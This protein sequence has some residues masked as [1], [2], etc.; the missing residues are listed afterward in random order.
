[1]R[2]LVPSF[3]FAAVSLCAVPAWADKIAVLPFSSPRNL[4]KPELEQARGWTREAVL[5]KGHTFATPD[6]M[7]SAEAAVKDGVP[8]TSQEYIAA[9]TAVGAPWT[10]A[11]RVE[12]N[13][14]PPST[15]P[16]GTVEEGYTT[17]RI[18]LEACLVASG[19]VES[20]AREVLADD[21]DAIAEMIALLVRPQGIADAEIPWERAGV[22]RPKPKPKPPA[23][24]PQ[25]R[26]PTPQEPPPQAPPPSKPAAPRAVY[27][28]GHALAI[29]ASIGVSNAIVRP[30]GARGPSWALPVGAVVGVALPDVLAGLE[31]KANLTSQVVGPR[32]LE[33][34][35]GARYA[36]APIG[37]GV[38]F[39]VGPELLLGAHVA[40]G[41][42]KTTRFLTHG[43]LFVAYG[44]TENL[45]AEVAGDLAV[46]AGGSGTLL[47]GGATARAVVR[48]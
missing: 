14:I 17:Y 39:F 31:L 35:A 40:L 21:T 30:S 41:A 29:G 15:L 44:I 13:D 36:F 37:D 6:E 38:R 43:A 24:P 23:P 19:R 11:A 2:R 18:E 47:L 46:A 22:A 28:A 34:A 4:S 1:M 9:G 26:E 12:R 42:D 33:A 48:F 20:L 8:D 10:I 5:K 45:Q 3:V 16:D 27:G 7:V 25:P 32:A